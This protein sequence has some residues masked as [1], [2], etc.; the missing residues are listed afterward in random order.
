MP[1]RF[2]RSAARPWNDARD[3]LE[4]VILHEPMP[5]IGLAAE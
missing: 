4:G 3:P 5:G 1:I 2:V